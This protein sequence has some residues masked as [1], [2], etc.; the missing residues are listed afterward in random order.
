[1]EKVKLGC[2][3]KRKLSRKGKKI[4]WPKASINFLDYGKHNLA[5]AR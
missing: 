2:Q 4:G 1:M 5:Q 3:G